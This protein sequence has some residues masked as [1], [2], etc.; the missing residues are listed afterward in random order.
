LPKLPELP[1]IAEIEKPKPEDK[2]YRR[3]TRMN[4]DQEKPKPLKRG[5][6]EATEESKF[7]PD[8]RG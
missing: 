5:G 2:T 4:A 8:L 7:T 3:F 1:K 6:T